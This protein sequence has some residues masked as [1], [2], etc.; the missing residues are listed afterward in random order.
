MAIE[1]GANESSAF[2]AS[3]I[4]SVNVKYL[5][6]NASLSIED[7]YTTNT[8]THFFYTTRVRECVCVL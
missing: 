4:V 6:V 2:T 1:N 5:G 8:A 3:V 7:L